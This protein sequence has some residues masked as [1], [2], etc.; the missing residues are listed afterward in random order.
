MVVA[1]KTQVTCLT[2]VFNPQLPASKQILGQLF[3]LKPQCLHLKQLFC[4]LG[5]PFLVCFSQ[6][7]R[8][9]SNSSTLKILAEIQSFLLDH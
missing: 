3:A 1:S 7:N 4:F 9:V 5:F 8:V 2:R 6:V